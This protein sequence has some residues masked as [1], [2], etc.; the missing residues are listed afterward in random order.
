MQ[1]PGR[2]SRHLQQPLAAVV[3]EC[4][5]FAAKPAPEEQEL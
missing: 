5:K 2:L 4:M 1:W 3:V